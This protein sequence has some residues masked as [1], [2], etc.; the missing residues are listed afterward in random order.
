MSSG[1]IFQ[2]GG[3]MIRRIIHVLLMIAVAG[4]FALPVCGA[5]LLGK[6]RIFI[7]FTNIRPDRPG[8]LIR[9]N[10]VPNHDQPFG[11]A[12]K[13]VYVGRDGEADKPPDACLLYTSPSPRDG[14]LSRMP[15]SA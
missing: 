9:L 10:V 15:S 4:L 12:G 13:T 2:G 7:R 11:W 5:E 8:I 6:N 1:T 14:L 3:T